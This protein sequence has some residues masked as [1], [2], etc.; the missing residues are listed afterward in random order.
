[1][2]ARGGWRHGAL[3]SLLGLG[4]LNAFGG[5]IYGLL[6]AEGVPTEWLRGSPFQ[7]YF[8]PSLVLFVVVGGSCLFSLIAVLARSSLAR[9]S[10]LGTGVILLGWI[11]V[12]VSI[13]GYVSWLQPATAIAGLTILALTLSPRGFS[14]RATWSPGEPRP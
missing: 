5:G 3:A 4:A 9:P 11:A 1:M 13:I 10:A 2:N 7:D 14:S 8:V 12:Q 6:G